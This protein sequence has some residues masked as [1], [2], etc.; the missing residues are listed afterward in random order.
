MKKLSRKKGFTL[1]ELIIAMAILVIASGGIGLAVET[2]SSLYGQNTSDL[3]STE[4]TDK[5]LECFKGKGLNSLSSMYNNSTRVNGEDATTTS[6]TKYLY[7]YFNNDDVNDN[8]EDSLN[9]IL[10]NTTN[11]QMVDEGI[12]GAASYADCSSNN[13][14]NYKYGAIVTLT[15]NYDYDLNDNSTGAAAA[16][17][18]NFYTYK[19]DVKLYD[20]E[21][22]QNVQSELNVLVSR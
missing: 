10:K 5:I 4:Y 7:L 20:F 3:K 17:R 18:Y 13:T 2:S 8:T 14:S 15:K 6:T 19:I 22:G 9:Y 1:V 11:F 21:K 16:Q 12:N